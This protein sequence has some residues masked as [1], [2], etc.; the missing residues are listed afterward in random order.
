MGGWVLVRAGPGLTLPPLPPY[1]ATVERMGW[2][3][4]LVPQQHEH[5]VMLGVI[6][7]LRQP[8]LWGK[9]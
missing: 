5:H 8:G 2:G 7:D 4:H 6:L 1:R 3:A 9:S